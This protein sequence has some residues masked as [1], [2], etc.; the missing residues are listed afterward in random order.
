MEVILKLE[1]EKDKQAQAL[2]ENYVVYEQE[3]EMDN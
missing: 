1:N 3:K 2:Q